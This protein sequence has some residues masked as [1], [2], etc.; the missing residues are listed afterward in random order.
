LSIARGDERKGRGGWET[1]RCQPA[2]EGAAALT[3]RGTSVCSDLGP[4]A[5]LV[6][7]CF[8]D[9]WQPYACD[10]PLFWSG[11]L[12]GLLSRVLNGMRPLNLI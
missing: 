9:K 11:F 10:K 12:F 8:G 7:V 5:P 1:R 2:M 6:R 3:H 4:F